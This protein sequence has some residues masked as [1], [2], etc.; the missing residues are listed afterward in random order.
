MSDISIAQRYAKPL[1]ELGIE[2][3]ILD[4]IYE[5]MLLF[6]ETCEQNSQFRAV[7][8]PIRPG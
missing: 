4:K 8:T 7:L 5:D 6:A 2:K 3:G 1:V